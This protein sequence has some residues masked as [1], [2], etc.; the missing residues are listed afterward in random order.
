MESQEHQFCEN[1]GKHITILNPIG[2]IQTLRE[3]RRLSFQNI[4]NAITVTKEC[5][6]GRSNSW[7]V[8]TQF[9]EIPI[10][11]T[12]PFVKRK[13]SEEKVKLMIEY[14][15]TSSDD[16]LALAKE[17]EGIDPPIDDDNSE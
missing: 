11:K 16:D 8:H 9:Q 7:V 1:K 17:F 10:A 2:I 6:A 14:Y 5:I 12:V 4:V 13:P 3:T 15:Q